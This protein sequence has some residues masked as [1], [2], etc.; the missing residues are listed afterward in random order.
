MHRLAL[1]VVVFSFKML[2]LL[3][4][5]SIR[6]TSHSYNG[7]IL[8]LEIFSWVLAAAVMGPLVHHVWKMYFGDYRHLHHRDMVLTLLTGYYLAFL[9]F[10]NYLVDYG[11]VKLV[12]FLIMEVYA[13][14]LCF[15]TKEETICW[16]K[17][18]SDTANVETIELKREF[19]DQ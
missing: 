18:R 6:M 9:F 1:E 4:L 17:S 15:I 14:N 11:W 2:L 12:R 3:A 19:F 10:S 8:I 16:R 5:Y 13:I 7:R